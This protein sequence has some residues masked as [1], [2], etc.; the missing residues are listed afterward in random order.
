MSATT[1]A[2]E[3]DVASCTPACGDKA[4]GDG[5]GGSRGECQEG[6]ARTGE[7]MCAALC[8]PTA[9]ARAADDGCGGS[10][11]SARAM[12]A[13]R[14]LRHRADSIARRELR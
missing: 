6:E 14:R 8:I 7:G 10:V 1:L 2:P 9:R 4:C 12:R 3:E 5:C 11:V 13:P